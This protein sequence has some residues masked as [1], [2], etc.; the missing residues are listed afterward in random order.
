MD[1]GK[2][3][4]TFITNPVSVKNKEKVL[5]KIKEFLKENS[6]EIIYT[7]YQGHA[8][9]IAKH[10]IKK[11]QVPVAVGGDGTVNEVAYATSGTG[12]EFG[13]IPAGS[14]NAVAGHFNI[15]NDTKAALE[16]LKKGEIKKADTGRINDTFFTMSTGV[17]FD[18]MVTEKMAEREKR[19]FFA[20]AE[21]VLKAWKERR[22]IPIRF[23]ADRQEHQTEAFMFTVA[24]TS[25]F[26]NGVYIAP[27]ADSNDGKLDIVVIEPFPYRAFLSLVA[28]ARGFKKRSPYIKRYTAS[29]IEIDCDENLINLDGESKT[30]KMPATIKTTPADIKIIC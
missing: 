7:E 15:P 14:G 24:N 23:V 19:G 25:Q 29:H 28:E 8:T 4:F 12:F 11:G 1:S 13:I 26:G 5:E 22:A 10:S 18:A 21:I 17:G 16:T 9:E 30:I 20:Y 2:R 3:P 27:E 6:G